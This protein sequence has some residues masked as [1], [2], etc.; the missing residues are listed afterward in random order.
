M[1]DTTRR[2]SEN[3]PDLMRATPHGRRLA[4][5]LA[6]FAIAL[7]VLFQVYA[8]PYF[9]T[10][11]DSTSTPP[12]ADAIR[13]VKSI[14]FGIAALGVASS[15]VLILHAQKFLQPRQC[16]PPDAW[17]WRD[18]KVMRGTKAVRF[19]WAYIAVGIATCL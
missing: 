12:S 4:A 3:P 15:P 19:A 10:I 13:I 16:P 6:I 2:A 14:F 9:N 17:L 1:S 5:F 11:I 8:F 18:T 7:I